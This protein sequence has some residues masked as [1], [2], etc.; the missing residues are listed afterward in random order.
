MQS[1]LV[2][3]DANHTWSLTPLPP[4]KKPIGCCWVYKIKRHSDGTIERF[5]ACLVAK[6][7]TQLEGLDYHD[8]FSPTAKMITVHCLLALAAAQNWSLHQFDVNN[9]FLHGD[10]HE[11]IYMT[12][13]LGL[14]GQEENQV[15]RLHKSLYGLK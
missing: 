2:A 6:G 15:C 11:E 9:A 14:Q 7:Y 4:G 10:L 1:E 8:T 12:L 3:L 13:P 5:K